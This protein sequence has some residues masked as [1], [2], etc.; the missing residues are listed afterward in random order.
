MG[1]TLRIIGLILLAGAAWAALAGEFGWMDRALAD[2]WLPPLIK[3]GI[4]VLVSGVALGFLAPIFRFLGKGRCARCGTS[5]EKGQTYCADHLQETV[6]E[7]Q[8]Q[9]RER[10][11]LY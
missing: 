9:T 6:H 11:Q 4:A 1:G 8:R 5:I 10:H 7:Y 2:A 3:A